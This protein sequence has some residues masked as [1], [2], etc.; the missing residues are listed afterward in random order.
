MYYIMLRITGVD[1]LNRQMKRW[2][3]ILD[4]IKIKLVQN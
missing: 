4:L 3:E 1:Y 2:G